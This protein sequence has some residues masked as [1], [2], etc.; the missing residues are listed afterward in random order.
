MAQPLGFHDLDRPNHVCHLHKAIYG[1]KQ[2]P[3]AWYSELR[4]YLLS[5][6][7]VNSLVDT[8]LFILKQGTYFVYMLIYVDDIVLTGTNN[9][10]LQST[11]DTLA[12]R[13]SLKDLGNL[14]YLLGIEA[15][16]TTSGLHL[17]QR[18]Y[19]LDLLTRSN[20]LTAKPV[21][22]PMASSPKLTLHTGSRLSD[23]TEFRSIVGSLQ[24]LA[25]TRPDISYCVNRLSQFMHV[26]TDS[27]LQVA[28]WVL[29]YLAGTPTHGIFLRRDNVFSLHAFS[30]ADWAGDA[31]D[32]ISTNAYVIY[33]GQHPI[34]WSCKKQK[35]VVRSSTEAEYRAVANTSSE[36][37]W[38]TSL[39]TEL[40]I[41]LSQV[42]VVYC[43]NVGATYLCANPVFHSRMK[44]V[45][46]DYHF[47]RNQ[48][49]AGTLR[50]SHISTCDQL[51]DVLT[52]PLPHAPFHH[53]ICKIG[54]SKAPP[55]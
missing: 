31:D 6:G 20:M 47:I 51:A 23:P 2:A 19:I 43:D 33:I 54:V 36:L 4:N 46:L 5:I 39:L 3:R 49:Q 52:K 7:F 27:H 24:Y 14:S 35:T 40:G 45:A 29:S 10:L 25:F 12:A 37:R 13:F 34:S 38:I 22:T 1:L 17:T 41:H 50:V 26:P 44:H 48:V 11:I 55:S 42:S 16:R 9:I 18:R 8:S 30:V 21:N 53:L 32:L 15:M 28:K